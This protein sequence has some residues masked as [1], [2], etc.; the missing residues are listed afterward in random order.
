MFDT[1]LLS[2]YGRR[3][4][5]LCDKA[6]ATVMARYTYAEHDRLTLTGTHSAME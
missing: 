4:K 5:R 3:L 6:E 2:S 1:E